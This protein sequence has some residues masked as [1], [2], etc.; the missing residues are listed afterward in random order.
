M[1]DRLIWVSISLMILTGLV[2]MLTG[3]VVA[4]GS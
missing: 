3:I 2:V 4:L 1:R